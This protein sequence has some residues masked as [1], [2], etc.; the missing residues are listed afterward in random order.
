MRIALITEYYYPHLGGVTEHVVNLSRRFTAAGHRPVVVTANMRGQP[1]DDANVIRVGRSRVIFSNGSFARVTFGRHL[2]A[3]VEAVLRREHIDVVHL[4]GPLTP[5]LG[6]VGA[7]AAERFGVPIVATFHSWFPR[8]AAARVF[9]GPLQRRLDRMAA[10]IAVSVPVVDA[11]SRY[12]VADWEV[13]PNGVDLAYFHPNGRSP[14]GVLRGEPR[15]LFLGRLDPRNGLDT[16]L[17]ALPAILERY[18]TARLTVVGDGPLRAYY[19][20]RARPLGPT[21]T[22]VGSVYDERNAYYGAAD[23]YVCPTTR[24]SFGITLLEAM[25]AGLPMVVSDITGFRELVDGTDAAVR[26]PPN[27]PAQWAA[28]V[29]AMLG[30]PDRRAA[31]SAAGREAAGSYAWPHIA[32]RVMNVYERVAR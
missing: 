13:I 21:V 3:R 19:E 20:K 5:T 30:D 2:R 8:S 26:V 24:A 17:A 23:L 15:L 22:F 7:A 9:R 28:A 14:L 6:L 1:A 31:M 4:H 32:R 11:H 16:M 12:F 25:A 29:I 18:P 27:A 10:T